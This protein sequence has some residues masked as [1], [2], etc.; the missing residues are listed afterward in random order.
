MNKNTA[1]AATNPT[2][3]YVIILSTPSSESHPL[4]PPP[5]SNIAND[6]K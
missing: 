4:D 5:L 2:L 3:K 6:V 1:A